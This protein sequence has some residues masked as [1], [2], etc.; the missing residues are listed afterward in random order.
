VSLEL[1]RNSAMKVVAVTLE[2]DTRGETVPGLH[3]PGLLE[4]K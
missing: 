2:T 1:P 3:L 4:P